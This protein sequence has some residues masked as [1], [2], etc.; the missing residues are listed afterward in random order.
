MKISPCSLVGWFRT[1]GDL[2]VRTELPPSTGK[3][4]YNTELITS[5]VAS[6]YK[7]LVYQLIIA[8]T[9]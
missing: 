2:K 4:A 8:N 3:K 9:L 6:L 5:R 7:K 1:K